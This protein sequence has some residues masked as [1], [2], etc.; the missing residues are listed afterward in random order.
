MDQI[1]DVRSLVA[2]ATL[3]K[4]PGP[5]P[6]TDLMDAVDLIL[7]TGCRI[8][9]IGALI[10][11]EIDLAA[12]APTLT[13]SGTIITETGAGTF[14]QPW[15]KSSAGYRTLY[16][17]PFAVGILLR[18]QVE[19]HDNAHGAVFPT[20]RGTWRQISN[21]RLLISAR[22]GQACATGMFQA[23]MSGIWSCRPHRRRSLRA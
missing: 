19:N 23:F 10:Y 11:A 18:R 14:R 13:V 3:S 5:R 16:L 6:T 22:R 21:V 9:E 7:G 15:T 2:T 12:S 20:R 4:R 8:G 1:Q 17:P